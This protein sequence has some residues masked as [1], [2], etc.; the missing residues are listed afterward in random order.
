MLEVAVQHAIA[1]HG[2]KNTPELRK[3]IQSS[4]ANA[5]FA[6][7][8]VDAA[9]QQTGRRLA[10]SLVS[11]M[12]TDDPGTPGL[13]L[14]CKSLKGYAF[15]DVTPTNPKSLVERFYSEVWNL[16]DEKAAREILDPALSFRGSL[17]PSRRGVDGF[18]E[19][20]RSIHGTLGNYQCIIE[21]LIATEQRAAARMRFTGVHRGPFFGVPAT[22]RQITWAG[23]A[24]FTVAAGKIAEIWVLGD[25]DS[26]KQQLGVVGTAAF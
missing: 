14:D 3:Q 17:G 20:M 25:V 13:R 11:C 4:A 8:G 18:I 19:Y 2:R 26:V 6:K 5:R 23:S 16:A 1:S 9:A 22:G 15:P 10:A 21:D 12:D 7:C 24:F